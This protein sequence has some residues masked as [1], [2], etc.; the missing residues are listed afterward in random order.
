MYMKFYICCQHTC[1]LC[2]MKMILASET[3]IKDATCNSTS[4]KGGSCIYS[5]LAS[6][7]DYTALLLRTPSEQ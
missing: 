7:C 5:Q 1:L 3:G 4:L 6:E 2:F